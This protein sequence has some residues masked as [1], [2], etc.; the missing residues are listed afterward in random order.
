MKAMSPSDLAE[1]R[2]E[3]SDPRGRRLVPLREHVTRLGRARD[4]HVRVI[5]GHVSKRHAEILRRGK[6]YVLRDVGS[7][8]GVFCNGAV[9]RER[10]LREGDVILLGKVCS[11]RIVFRTGEGARSKDSVFLTAFTDR[12]V[13]EHGNTAASAEPKSPAPSTAGLSGLQNLAR[14]LDLSRTL[15]GHLSPDEVVETVVDM[16]IEMTNAE[17][18]FVVLVGPDDQLRFVAVRG[19][20]NAA[21]APPA[22]SETIARQAVESKKPTIIADVAMDDGLAIAH[23]VVDLRLGSVIAIPLR[24]HVMPDKD[25]GVQATD[26]VF[27]VL[28][29]D[30]QK[31]RRAF[32]EVDLGILETL[33]RDASSAIENARLL[34]EA[35]QKRRMEEELVRAK[36]VQSAFVPDEYWSL[37]HFDVAGSYVPCHDLGGDYLGQFRHG[38]DAA[39][40]AVADVC[41]KGMHAALLAA[42]LQ[43]A[44]LV[45]FGTGRSLAD[46]VA[47]ANRVISEIAPVGKFISMVSCSLAPDGTLSYVNAGHCPLI[48]VR[49]DSVE[50]LV[51]GGVA[52]GLTNTLEY[53]EHT[54]QMAPGD[55]A[56]L[57]TD[58]VLEAMND[59]REPFGSERLE[60]EVAGAHGQPAAATCARLLAAVEAFSG[61][62]AADDDT[63]LMVISYRQPESR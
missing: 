14:F 58:G 38:K 54:V 19:C 61:G 10:E 57:Y 37:D 36:E 26:E 52:L 51:T 20:D 46:V 47:G 27:G 62:E 33:A 56:I 35:E 34:R 32:G 63:T 8:A 6:S 45:E 7:R 9:V 44:L 24:R 43:G 29:L 31:K 13:H 16:A 53:A 4:N 39:A 22:I 18:G 17:R 5:D 25:R 40:F 28:W 1:A 42:A 11:A 48:L 12:G 50:H 21:S 60:A 2:L 15:S 23:S 41:G 3:V 55:T 30:S 49:A 59:D